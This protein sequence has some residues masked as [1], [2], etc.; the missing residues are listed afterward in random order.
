MTYTT[1]Q[2][3][4]QARPRVQPDLGEDD[5]DE[6]DDWP[7]WTKSYLGGVKVRDYPSDAQRWALPGATG[8][9]T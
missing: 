8:T 9:P 2:P 6:G 3:C 7:S 1:S 4:R 5:L